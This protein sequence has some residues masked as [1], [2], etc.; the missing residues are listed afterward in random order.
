MKKGLRYIQPCPI[1]KGHTTVMQE[2]SFRSMCK[3]YLSLTDWSDKFNADA[4]PCRK[5][6]IGYVVERDLPLWE[7]PQGV[8]FGDKDFLSVTDQVKAIFTD[9]KSQV[10]EEVKISRHDAFD[11]AY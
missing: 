1:N 5:C 3:H 9:I 7:L 10:V 8:I 6:N 4:E 11:M 2:E